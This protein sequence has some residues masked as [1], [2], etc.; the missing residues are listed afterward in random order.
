V[1][2]SRAW[3]TACS[4][5]GHEPIPAGGRSGRHIGARRGNSREGTASGTHHRL[6]RPVGP[7][8]RGLARTRIAPGAR[9]RAVTVPGSRSRRSTRASASERAPSSPPAASPTSQRLR[10]TSAGAPTSTHSLTKSRSPG[11]CRSPPRTP[12]GRRRRLSR[13]AG[14]ATARS[15][16]RD[17]GR[18]LK[19]PG[20]T[21]DGRDTANFYACRCR[22]PIDRPDDDCYSVLLNAPR[23]LSRGDLEMDAREPQVRRRGFFFDTDASEPDTG[24]HENPEGFVVRAQMTRS[25]A[26]RRVVTSAAPRALSSARLGGGRSRRAAEPLAGDDGRSGVRTESATG[27]RQRTHWPR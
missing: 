9:I 16:S 20:V 2:R 5:A 8:H 22:I 23:S 10:V 1:G 11:R 17:R 27:S 21:A 25:S 6:S 26:S 3:I 7:H 4:R 18:T 19:A 12:R 15:S 24:E 13:H 14:T